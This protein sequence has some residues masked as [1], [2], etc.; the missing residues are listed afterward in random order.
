MKIRSILI[1]VCLIAGLVSCSVERKLTR[2]YKGKSSE[3]LMLQMG[4]PTRVEKVAGGRTVSIYE[5]SKFLKSAPI[6]TGAFQY[7]KFESPK[8]I[9]TEVYRFFISNKGV[10]ENVNYEVTYAR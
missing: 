1:L 4:R 3:E 2:E 9:K 7:D 8:A 5:K 10:I 6:N